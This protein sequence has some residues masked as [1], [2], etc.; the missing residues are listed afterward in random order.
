[1]LKL[2]VDL[3]LHRSAVRF[4]AIT[5]SYTAIAV[6]LNYSECSTTLLAIPATDSVR[7][8]SS[9]CCWL[10][11]RHRPKYRQSRSVLWSRPW[12]HGELRIVLC[13]GVPLTRARLP[14]VV[15]ER[16]RQSFRIS[17]RLPHLQRD[18]WPR[19]GAQLLH[20]VRDKTS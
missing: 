13:P 10:R 20:P 8:V 12:R 6:L 1:M 5:F 11:Q 17:S 16:P 14:V 2:A 3:S 9:A 4:C 18:V 15:R 19:R 7:S